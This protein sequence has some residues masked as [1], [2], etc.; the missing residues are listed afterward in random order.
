MKKIYIIFLVFFILFSFVFTT[1]S[2]AIDLTYD[3]NNISLSDTITSYK[4][5]CIVK[6][7]Y[8]NGET[9]FYALCSDTNEFMFSN[10]FFY[11][12]YNIAL[13]HSNGGYVYY[14]GTQKFSNL[15]SVSSLESNA[16][17]LGLGTSYTTL[18]IMYSN[19]NI[20][21]ETIN[22]NG[23]PCIDYEN[24]VFQVAPPAQVLLPEITQVEEIPQLMGQMMKMLIPVG[25]IVLL[26][27]LV[28][29]LTRLVIFRLT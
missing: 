17:G 6:Q 27:G 8:S 18:D 11:V 14:Y 23:F 7:T 10:G 13:N 29:F 22:S 25:L 3:G 26:A 16:N 4:Y 15:S 2:F 12:S 21:G 9:Y 19:S 28:I 5:Y 20:Y 24:V 1:N